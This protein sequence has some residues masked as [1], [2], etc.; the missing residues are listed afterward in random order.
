MLIIEVQ[1]SLKKE[2]N[3]CRPLLRNI[4]NFEIHS[5]LK[6]SLTELAQNFCFREQQCTVAYQF[7]LNVK[8]R[9]LPN[10][11]RWT[12]PKT[13]TQTPLAAR[14]FLFFF[15]FNHKTFQSFDINSENTSLSVI[16]YL[17]KLLDPNNCPC[18]IP[19]ERQH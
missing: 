8:R 11:R 2:F 1:T 6:I 7:Y 9:V 10:Q 5:Y 13:V 14:Y 19:D 15:F 3:K 12:H 17:M 4:Q 16:S 18:T